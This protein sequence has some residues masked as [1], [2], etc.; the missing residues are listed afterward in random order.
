MQVQ[1]KTTIAA[2][3]SLIYASLND[4]TLVVACAPWL[5]SVNVDLAER[6]YTAI[7]PF[8]MG[9]FKAQIGIKLW[10]VEGLPDQ[11]LQLQGS[12]VSGGTAVPVSTH[13]TLTPTSEGHTEI[14]WLI[15]AAVPDKVRPLVR[16]FVGDTPQRFAA[17]FFTCLQEKVTAQ[18][19]TRNEFQ[20]SKFQV[21]G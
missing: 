14:T 19:E 2:A 11:Q 6:S 13:I 1:D 20:V 12:L 9:Q 15:Q 3:P 7:I 5:K 18:L 16:Q 17:A 10:W 4:P 8:T 21:S